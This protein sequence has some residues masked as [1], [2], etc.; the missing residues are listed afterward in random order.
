MPCCHV[1]LGAGVLSQHN[2]TNVYH[3]SAYLE[4]T[5]GGAPRNSLCPACAWFELQETHGENGV[6]DDRKKKA[7]EGQLCRLFGSTSEPAGLRLACSQ[8]V[9]APGPALDLP[10][11]HMA[12]YYNVAFCP[13]FLERP[14]CIAF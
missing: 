12:S 6:G 8:A 10:G 13:S 1:C 4:C 11:I 3:C 7:A 5:L 9:L 2:A 14:R